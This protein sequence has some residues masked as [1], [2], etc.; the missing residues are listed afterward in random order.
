MGL[1]VRKVCLCVSL[2]FVLAI[3][4]GSSVAAEEQ[5]CVSVLVR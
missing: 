2:C 4:G 3:L 5:L 1:G